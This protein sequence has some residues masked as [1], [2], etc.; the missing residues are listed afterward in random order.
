[1]VGSKCTRSKTA[2]MKQSVT[3]PS[4]QDGA[5]SSH[6]LCFTAIVSYRATTVDAPPF[7]LAAESQLTASC[8]FEASTTLLPLDHVAETPVLP[9]GPVTRTTE[10]SH[11]LAPA[12]LHSLAHGTTLFLQAFSIGSDAF[13]HDEAV[14]HD[15]TALHPNT[16]VLSHIAATTYDSTVEQVQPFPPW[17]PCSMY[18]HVYTSNETLARVH[19]GSEQISPPSPRSQVDLILRV[20]Q[21]T[22]RMDDQNDLVR[23]L[24][25]QIDLVQNLGLGP[26]RE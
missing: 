8:P 9:Q 17:P 20:D 23:Q 3:D 21:L 7:G 5:A 2:T 10:L 25:N 12:T 19:L 24:F 4:H 15:T 26:Q 14:T 22:Q 1:M 16:T 6:P 11:D 13:H 18:T